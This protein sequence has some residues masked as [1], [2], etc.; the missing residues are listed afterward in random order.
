[1]PGLSVTASAARLDIAGSL[2]PRHVADLHVTAVNLPT[3]D[4]RTEVTG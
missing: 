4:G 2:N 1:M 3:R